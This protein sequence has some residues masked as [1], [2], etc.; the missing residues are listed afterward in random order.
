MLTRIYAL[1]VCFS[2]ILCIAI[3]TGIGL[4]DVVQLT[5]P[6]FTISSHQKQRSP[7]DRM[8]VAPYPGEM[9]QGDV[10][11]KPPKTLPMTEEEIEQRHT[12]RVANLIDG[13]RHDAKVSLVRILIVLLVSI[14]LFLVHWRFARRLDELETNS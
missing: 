11:T 7:M 9:I 13:V 2:A 8:M 6:E 1:A 12:E 5:I 3:S 10:V 4:Y 14:P